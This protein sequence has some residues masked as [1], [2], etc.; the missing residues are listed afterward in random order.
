MIALI[1][2]RAPLFFIDTSFTPAYN[3]CHKFATLYS[4]HNISI[5]IKFL[6]TL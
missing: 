5:E 6:W 1:R 4:N 3:R 2:S